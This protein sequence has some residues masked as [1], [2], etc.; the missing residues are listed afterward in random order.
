[1][2]VGLAAED[3]LA[4]WHRSMVIE[5]ASAGA[6]ILL[7][8]LLAFAAGHLL[9]AQESEKERTI[10]RLNRLAEGST[11]ITTVHDGQTLAGCVTRVV[12]FLFPGAQ[13]A[14]QFSGGSI[15]PIVEPRR[16]VVPLLS[17]GKDAVGSIAVTRG[18]KGASFNA[19][20]VAVLTQLSH[21]ITATLDNLELIEQSQSLAT[22]AERAKDDEAKARKEIEDVFATM[23]EAVYALDT[24]GRLTFLNDN[25]A[26]IF[27]KTKEE[28]LGSPLWDAIPHLKGSVVEK[29]FQECLTSQKPDEFEFEYNAPGGVRWAEVRAFPTR[30]A[31][32]STAATSP[33]AWKPRPSCVNRRRWRRSAN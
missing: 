13:A 21:V 10:A 3:V 25:A 23:S 24:K 11:E 18:P 7:I 20:D 29:R 8:I 1:V 32:R 9:T 16:L 4:G 19:Q 30:T 15:E 31:S 22:Q 26:R 14:F 12:Q 5:S 27:L 33:S 6:L 2:V 17:K 28:L